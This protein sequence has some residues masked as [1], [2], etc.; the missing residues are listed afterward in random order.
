MLSGLKIVCEE[1]LVDVLVAVEVVSDSVKSLIELNLVASSLLGAGPGRD[2]DAEQK[3]G[4]YEAHADGEHED[5]NVHNF[6]LVPKAACHLVCLEEGLPAEEGM[7][8]KQRHQDAHEDHLHR[9]TLLDFLHLFVLISAYQKHE[10]EGR[11]TVHIEEERAVA[12]PHR[13]RHVT[14]QNQQRVLEALVLFIRL[15]SILAIHSASL[16]RHFQLFKSLY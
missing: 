10:G 9:L 12:R 11:K 16:W 14:N 8:V 4:E 13:N 3:Q 15:V 6:T 5:N 2:H 1:S 7:E